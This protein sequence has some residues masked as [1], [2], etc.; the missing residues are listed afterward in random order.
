MFVYPALYASLF[1]SVFSGICTIINFLF[2]PSSAFSC[3]T[4]CAVV[5]EPE[6]KSRISTSCS[7]LTADKRSC[8]ISVVGFGKSN[9]LKGKITL[10]S[11]VPCAVL[12][13]S[14]VIKF[15]KGIVLSIDLPSLSTR[16]YLLLYTFHCPS[17][18]LKT[19]N[20]FSTPHFTFE[21]LHK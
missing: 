21:A 20:P 12:H 14:D 19:I 5:A 3:I 6:K 18:F 15:L 1:S 17:L 16:A 11:C 2:P 8:R 4:A 7:V 13:C 10:I 9:T